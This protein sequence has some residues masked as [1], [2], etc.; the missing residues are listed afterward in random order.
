[1]SKIDK[2]GI[3]TGAASITV[4]FLPPWN[5]LSVL[6]LTSGWVSILFCVFIPSEDTP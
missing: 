6:C 2:F 1:M 5:G 3:I 4:A